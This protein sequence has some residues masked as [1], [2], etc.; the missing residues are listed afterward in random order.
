M[1]LIEEITRLLDGKRN[2]VASSVK[3]EDTKDRGPRQVG[4]RIF[5]GNAAPTILGKGAPAHADHAGS[6]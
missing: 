3:A 6:C 4:E 5:K 2:A 1:V